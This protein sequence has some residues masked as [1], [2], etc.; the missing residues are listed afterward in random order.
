M[1]FDLAENEME[2]NFKPPDTGGR[3]IYLNKHL[4]MIQTL[5]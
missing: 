2:M 1:T 3:W 4:E 5:F